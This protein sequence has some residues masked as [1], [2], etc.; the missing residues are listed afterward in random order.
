MPASKEELEK[1]ENLY[2]VAVSE[3]CLLGLAGFCRSYSH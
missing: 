1:G 2:L 3:I